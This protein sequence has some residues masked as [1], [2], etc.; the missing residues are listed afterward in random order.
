[1]DHH[2]VAPVSV[3]VSFLALARVA[4]WIVERLGLVPE[5]KFKRGGTDA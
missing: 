1:M 3:V 4:V 5:T 2:C